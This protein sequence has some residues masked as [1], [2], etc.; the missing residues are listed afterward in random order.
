MGSFGYW[1]QTETDLPVPNYSFLPNVWI[2]FIRLLVFFCLMELVWA[3]PKMIPLNGI[4]CII[5]HTCHSSN[6]KVGLTF[7]IKNH[8]GP[9]WVTFAGA[10]KQD[11]W[12]GT[13]DIWCEK[14]RNLFPHN[15]LQFGGSI[16]VSFIAVARMKRCLAMLWHVSLG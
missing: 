5:F 2:K 1:D 8:Q 15:F 12:T 16:L 6:L 14:V 4:N 11:N 10:L 13:Q 9:S 7:R 3:W